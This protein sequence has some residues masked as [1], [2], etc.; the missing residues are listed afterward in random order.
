MWNIDVVTC[1]MSFHHYPNPEK[2]FRSLHRV[3]CPGGRL[4]LRDM[5]SK[6]KVMMWF[7]N[8]VEIPLIN[9]VLHKGDV[10]VYSEADIQRLCGVS[11]MKLES[12]EVRKCFRE[13]H[14][15]TLDQYFYGRM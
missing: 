9:R 6:S 1:S 14:F 13:S 10:H 7:F 5:A 11:G 2:F 4:I 8:H 12:Y 15:P 3:L